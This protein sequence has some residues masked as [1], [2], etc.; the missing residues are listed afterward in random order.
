MRRWVIVYLFVY[1]AV[2]AGAAVTAWR[3]GL[4]T[5]FGPTWTLA[6]ITFAV[7]LGGLLAAL[8]RK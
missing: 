1:F 7:A 6:A 3:S 4:I 8:S 5:H 2:L